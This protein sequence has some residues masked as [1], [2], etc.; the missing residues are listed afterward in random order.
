MS[1]ETGRMSEED[2]F[3]GVR[4]TI[5]PPSETETSAE[6]GEIDVEVVDDRPEEDQRPPAASEGDDGGA[7]EQDAQLTEI[8]PKT[9]KKAKMGVP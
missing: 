3:L 8:G 6:V 4:T 7:T 2:K 5:E 9:H 1:E